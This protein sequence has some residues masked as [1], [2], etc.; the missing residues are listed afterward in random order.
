MDCV[1]V[2]T[3]SYIGET[4]C[5]SVPSGTHAKADRTGFQLCAR[6]KYSGGGLDACLDCDNGLQSEAGSSICDFFCRPG[7]ILNATSTGCDDCPTGKFARYGHSECET[8]ADGHAA[9]SNATVSC[10]ICPAGKYIA[11]GEMDVA[12]TNS[13]HCLDCAVGKFSAKGASEC[14][15]CEIGKVKSGAATSERQ[16]IGCE[17]RKPNTVLTS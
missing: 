9:T 4:S 7:T 5:T 8:C 17:E 11:Y 13:T 15:S 14:T 1:E 6:G 12:S 3:Y 10:E 16:G 2:G